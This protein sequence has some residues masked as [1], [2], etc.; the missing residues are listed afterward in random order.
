[1]VSLYAQPDS[2]LLRHSYGTLW[3]AQYLGKRALGIVT[4]KSIH[5]VV[6]MIPF[7]LSDTENANAEIHA[8]FATCYFVSEKPFLDFLGTGDV[9]EEPDHDEN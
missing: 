5:S 6:G 4:I 1:L 7:I 9:S 3:V 2:E 8:K